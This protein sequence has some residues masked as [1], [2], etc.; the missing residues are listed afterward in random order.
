[1][2]KNIAAFLDEKA[3]TVNVVLGN[4]SQMYTYITNTPNLAVG[5]AVIVPMRC[6][7]RNNLSSAATRNGWE[8]VGLDLIEQPS[9]GRPLREHLS[10]NALR[11]AVIVDVH[12]SVSIEPN[13]DTEYKW[14]VS[15]VDLTGYEAILDRNQKLMDIA[16]DAYKK[17][18]RKSFASQILGEMDDD[19]QTELKKLLGQG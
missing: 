6:D 15:K 14:I 17:R 12:D 7:K 10:N 16:T 19:A 13:S 1:M 18:M 9:S 4:G 3:Y 8:S 11:I 2:D 5:D